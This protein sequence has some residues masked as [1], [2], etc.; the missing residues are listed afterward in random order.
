MNIQMILTM[1]FKGIKFIAFMMGAKKERYPVK[2]ANVPYQKVKRSKAKNIE[3]V[4]EKQF[5]PINKKTRPGIALKNPNGAVIH[6]IS[7]EKDIAHLKYWWGKFELAEIKY[8][9]AQVGLE[10]ERVAAFMPLDEMAHH[11]ADE[12]GNLT[13]RGIEL[14]TTKGDKNFSFPPAEV[15]NLLHILS[16]YAVKENWDMSKQP[17]IMREGIPIHA[18]REIPVT[19]H[20]FWIPSKRGLK[21]K[22]PCPYYWL[23]FPEKFT[24]FLQDLKS[25]ISRV[26][27]GDLKI[28]MR[29]SDE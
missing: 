10:G 20:G 26:R 24:A 11:C 17:E 28:K 3:I 22:V 16:F 25:T 27:S 7:Q 1:I 15:R 29:Y 21:S 14:A 19:L 4:I 18:L 9:S 23:K 2:T 6:N 13:S 5:L 12:I 8:G